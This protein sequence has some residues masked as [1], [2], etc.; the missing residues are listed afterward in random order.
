MFDHCDKGNSCDAQSMRVRQRGLVLML[1]GVGMVILGV[2]V[3]IGF[4]LFA[5]AVG[6]QFGVIATGLIVLGIGTFYIGGI[7]A[8]MGIDI[9]SD[10]GVPRHFVSLK[11]HSLFKLSHQIRDFDSSLFQRIAVANGDGLIGQRLTI[12]GDAERSARFVLSAITSSYCAL[13]VVVNRHLAF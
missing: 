7:I 12:D 1:T 5:E 2:L 6:V 13:L 10:W 4:R 8:V 11:T 3:T 9:R